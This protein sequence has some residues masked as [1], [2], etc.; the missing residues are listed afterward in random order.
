MQEMESYLDAFIRKK[1]RWIF[2]SKSLVF[3]LF[4]G[5]HLSNIV[6]YEAFRGRH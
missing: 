5:C 2:F 4:I 3:P 6:K 1:T